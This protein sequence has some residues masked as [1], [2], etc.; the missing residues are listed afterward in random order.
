MVPNPGMFS[1]GSLPFPLFPMP[2]DVICEHGGLFLLNISVSNQPQRPAGL[3]GTMPGAGAGA[4]PGGGGMPTTTRPPGGGMQPGGAMPPGGAT[5]PPT[6]AASLPG[7]AAATRPPTG[8][9]S[10]PGGAGAT[11]PP[12]AGGAGALTTSRFINAIK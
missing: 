7:G 9:G 5:R 8:A 10:L 2:C 3:P 11:R 4:M 12:T 1:M 6:G